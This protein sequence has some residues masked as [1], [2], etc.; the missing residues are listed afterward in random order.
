MLSHLKTYFT[1]KQSIAVG[2]AFWGVGFL[3]GNWATLIPSIKLKFNLDDAQLGLLLLS[4]PLGAMVFNPVAAKLISSYGMRKIH[5][6]GMV[7]L[8]ICYSLPL[9]MPYLPLVSLGLISIGM[10]LSM[11][12]VAMN[13]CATAIEQNDKIT[14]LSTSHGMFS[15]GLMMG[16][17]ACSF[18]LGM[19]FSPMFY[20]AI[21]A[22]FIL[23]LGQLS[24]SAVLSINEENTPKKEEQKTKFS[25]PT[26][27]LLLMILI[28]ICTNI[29]EGCMADWTAVYMR[30]VVQTSPYFIGWG[31]AGYSLFMAL[32]RF[33][34]DGIIPRIGVNNVLVYGGILAILGVVIAVLLPYTFS[35]IIG[36]SL[37]GA[38]VSCAAPIL[39]GS[40]A[41]VPGKAKG[42]GL[43][44]M[45]TFS[46]GGFLLGPVLIGFISEAVS[47][48]F[49]FGVV[50]FLIG[51]WVL[52]SKRVDLY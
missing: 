49:A 10:S 39:Y 30:D 40:A 33:L 7:I 5:I 27:I 41:R 11:L 24:R 22:F 42:E 36:F 12:N 35:T 18:A 31:L 25:F 13:T 52:L 51:V 15:L 45:N 26:G 48:P 1:H 2:V 21:M 9:A 46:M 4:L 14:I 3:F 44:T 6:L 50:A 38:G 23:I 47:L 43:A 19:N 29:T 16:S 20:M 37:V 34:G 8:P 17:V 28:S 32:G